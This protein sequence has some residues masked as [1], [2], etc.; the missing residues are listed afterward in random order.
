MTR[1][2]RALALSA[3]LAG[4]L[5]SCT[6]PDSAREPRPPAA[7]VVVTE[8]KVQ[9]RT[10]TTTLATTL[11][12]TATVAETTVTA[13]ETRWAIGDPAATELPGTRLFGPYPDENVC[14]AYPEAT[15]EEREDGWYLVPGAPEPDAE[16]DAEP[17]PAQS[18]PAEPA[19]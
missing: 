10:A 9:D 6:I 16:P 7:T 12:E 1:T 19:G 4:T 13:T 5:A 14:R 3:A 15:C 17:G 18:E 8:T 11:A 2:L